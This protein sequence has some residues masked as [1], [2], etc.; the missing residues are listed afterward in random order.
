MYAV[1]SFSPLNYGIIN[2]VNPEMVILT[3]HHISQAVLH[4][5]DR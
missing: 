4:V 3:I 5:A 1:K 2:A